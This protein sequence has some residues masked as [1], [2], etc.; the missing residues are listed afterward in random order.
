MTARSKTRD[1]RIQWQAQIQWHRKSPNA[2]NTPILGMRDPVNIRRFAYLD[3]RKSICAIDLQI[4]NGHLWSKL[5]N[6]RCSANTFSH[7]KTT[8]DVAKSPS[9]QP[10]HMHHS[11]KHTLSSS[12]RPNPRTHI[13]G[14][15][16]NESE[17]VNSMGHTEIRLM[18]IAMAF[19]ADPLGQKAFC[20][21]THSYLFACGRFPNR[22]MYW[23][24]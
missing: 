2:H 24:T 23:L 11:T 20:A 1:T 9:D 7:S 6:A 10:N 22:T 19:S 21:R 14:I 17:H 4:R 3:S 15:E 16:V 18:E 13:D 8:A 5:M 12:Q